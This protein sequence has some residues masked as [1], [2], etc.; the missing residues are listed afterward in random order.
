M[1]TN[2]VSEYTATITYQLRQEE[3]DEK[4]DSLTLALRAE[5]TIPIL[6]NKHE[7]TYKL[8]HI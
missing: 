6:T 5:G 8:F 1:P 7:Q 2:E 3:K 4:V